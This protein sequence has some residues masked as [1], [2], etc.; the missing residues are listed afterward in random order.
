M[1]SKSGGA[2][3]TEPEVP[4]KYVKASDISTE[5]FLAA[6]WKLTDGKAGYISLL[7]LAWALSSAERPARL[8]DPPDVSKF[9]LKNKANQL[10]LHKAIA[11]AQGRPE[12]FLVPARE[13]DE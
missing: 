12:L 2:S 13:T 1:D 8:V 4:I 9:A 6:A 7:D 5:V 10:V 11:D 3:G